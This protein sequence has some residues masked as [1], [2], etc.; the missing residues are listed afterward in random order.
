[1]RTVPLLESGQSVLVAPTP[2]APPWRMLVDVVQD[3]QITLATPEDEQ[4]PSEWNELTEVQITSLDRYSVHY[5]HVPIRRMGATRLVVGAPDDDTPVLRRAYARVFNPVPV[6]CMLLDVSGTH[7]TPFD[8]EVRDLGGGGCSF[9]ASIIPP[10]AATVVMSFVVDDLGP[11]VIVGRT[12]PRD[13]LPSI[14]RAL[15]RIE[16]VQIREAERDRIL[17]YVLLS[18]AA[19][20]HGTLLTS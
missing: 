5:I 2:E 6:S 7:W 16:F 9:V 15:T 3:G 11:I 13:D 10:E 1:M 19:R 8:A 17:R 20:R 12:L 18:L 4:L 14:G